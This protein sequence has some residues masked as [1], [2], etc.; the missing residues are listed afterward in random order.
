MRWCAVQ[1]SAMQCMAVVPHAG[2]VHCP[3]LGL[4]SAHTQMKKDCALPSLLLLKRV[5]QGLQSLGHTKGPLR[6]CLVAADQRRGFEQTSAQAAAVQLQCSSSTMH[7]CK[8]LTCCI[9][10][11]VVTFA[12]NIAG[13]PDLSNWRHSQLTIPG[14][15]FTTCRHFLQEHQAL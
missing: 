11:R 2:S 6:H 13:F 15:A 8:L 5:P 12:R 10:G 14:A 9:T 4:W 3:Q 7:Q 1:R